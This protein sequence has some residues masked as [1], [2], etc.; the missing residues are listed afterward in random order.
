MGDDHA[1]KANGDKG[2]D[3]ITDFYGES[4]KD[5]VR[6]KA[7]AESGVVMGEE[8]DELSDSDEL[9]EFDDDL[10]DDNL[11]FGYSQTHLDDFLKS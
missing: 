4:F 8:G 3:G 9:D 7:K 2:D 6:T 10:S 1:R 5:S 11:D